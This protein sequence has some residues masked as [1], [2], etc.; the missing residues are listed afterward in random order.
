M[1]QKV[2]KIINKEISYREAKKS[3]YWFCKT[4]QFACYRETKKQELRKNFTSTEFSIIHMVI[5]FHK[6]FLKI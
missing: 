2:S 3:Q 6:I 1:Q 5:H 4:I